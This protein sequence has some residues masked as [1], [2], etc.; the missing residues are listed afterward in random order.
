MGCLDG[1]CQKLVQ[2]DLGLRDGEYVSEHCTFM[3]LEGVYIIVTGRLQALTMPKSGI[4]VSLEQQDLDLHTADYRQDPTL[5]QIVLL[6]CCTVVLFHF[7]K[8]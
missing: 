4:R 8:C 5:P 2:G 6:Q 1:L 7:W 3:K